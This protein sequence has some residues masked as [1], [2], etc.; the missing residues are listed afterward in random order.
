MTSLLVNKNTKQLIYDLRAFNPLECTLNNLEN[1]DIV[2][3]WFPIILKTGSGI[4]KIYHININYNIIM[5]IIN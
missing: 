5:V 1:V 3:I 4:N 2:F